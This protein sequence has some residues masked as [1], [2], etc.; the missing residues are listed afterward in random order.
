MFASLALTPGEGGRAALLKLVKMTGSDRNRMLMRTECDFCG[1]EM[2]GVGKRM[3]AH[4]ARVRGRGTV[5]CK[6]PSP[7]A[8]ALGKKFRETLKGKRK[9]TAQK[10]RY[11]ELAHSQ[12]TSV[13]R[14]A[15]G[16]RKEAAD[17]AYTHAW[18]LPVAYLLTSVRPRT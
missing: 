14:W 4:F 9:A 11:A 1:R 5:V 12:L 8:I 13:R 7:V 15:D 6:K 18:C 2:L 17:K 10:G 16:A 3:A